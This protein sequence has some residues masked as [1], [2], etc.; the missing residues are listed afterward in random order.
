LAQTHLNLSNAKYFIID[1]N[2]N[3]K[4]S[5]LLISFLVLA[6]FLLHAQTDRIKVK[7]ITI[8]NDTIYLDNLIMKLTSDPEFANTAISL[9]EWD[10]IK[11]ILQSQKKDE[12]S[13]RDEFLICY[14][15][16]KN[17]LHTKQIGKAISCANNL[18]SVSVTYK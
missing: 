2:N 6:S 7:K 16:C 18:A 5:F 12:I 4:K 14:V 1:K 3:L 15:D 13:T 9:Q 8:L 17:Y 10:Q 11:N